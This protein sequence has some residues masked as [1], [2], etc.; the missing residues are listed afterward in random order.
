M[1]DATIDLTPEECIPDV[2]DVSSALTK[3]ASEFGK[4]PHVAFFPPNFNVDV[5]KFFTFGTL[6]RILGRGEGGLGYDT[7]AVH[8]EGDVDGMIEGGPTYPETLDGKLDGI[9]QNIDQLGQDVN[10]INGEIDNI[11][12]DLAG[13]SGSLGAI[14]GELND[15]Q[16][17]IDALG[18]GDP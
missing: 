14:G 13:I 2:P 5:S 15:L 12:G 4:R 6:G 18:D 9:D 7:C 16:G 11:N 10:N 8:I 17:Q 1:S 3:L